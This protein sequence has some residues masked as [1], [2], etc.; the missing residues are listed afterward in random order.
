[1]T[2]LLNLDVIALITGISA[3]LV[4]ALI[5]VLVVAHRKSVVI[6]ETGDKSRDMYEEYIGGDI[7]VILKKLG[8]NP[9]E[10]VSYCKIANVQPD[11]YSLILFRIAGLAILFCGVVA[12]ILLGNT[13]IM[14]A[15][16]L[17]GLIIM[18]GNKNKV[19]KIAQRRKELFNLE[20]PRFLDMLHSALVAN[21]PVQSAIEFTVAHLDGVLAEEMKYAL[22]ETEMGAKSWN[23][24]LFDVANKYENNNFSDFALDLTTAYNKGSSIE[25][26]VARKARQIKDS[27]MLTA[28]E[29]AAGVS[30]KV[31]VPV[32]IFKM[33]PL[34]G[35]ML[36]PILL[37]VK[38]A[39]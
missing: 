8:I 36:I 39:F 28:K 38:D 9:N 20:I 37:V 3:F 27:N 4:I 11:Y 7:R 14:V 15:A 31:L 35:S 18:E 22:A 21:I 5:G 30:S 24:A 10:Y 2:S 19:K 17:L 23:E 34:L 16:M 26:S 29:K 1:M 13:I 12:G 25:A 32:V 33:I 6:K